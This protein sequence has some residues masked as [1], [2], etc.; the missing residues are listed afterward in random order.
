MANECPTSHIGE[1][2]GAIWRLLS[3][4]GP[5]SLAKLVKAVEEPRDT[6]MQAV[7][8]LAR[9]GKLQITVN[10]RNREVSLLQVE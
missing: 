6:V 2:A 3:Q 7:G 5:M 4:N 9:E 10:G 1:V 8:W